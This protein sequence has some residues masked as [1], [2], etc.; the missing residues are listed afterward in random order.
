[1]VL[2]II[3]R[4][5]IQANMGFYMI[6]VFLLLEHHKKCVST[7]IFRYSSGSVSEESSICLSSLVETDESD[8]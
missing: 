3:K 4:Y 6:L 1:M 8:E 2:S 5:V 7:L